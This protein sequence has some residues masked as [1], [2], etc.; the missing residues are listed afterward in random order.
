MRD[1]PLKSA[2]FLLCAAFLFFPVAMALGN[3][4]MILAF[5]LG[6]FALWAG[7]KTVVR[8]LF[9]NPVVVC[10]LGLYL[11][12]VLGSL[13]TNAPS[14]D[15]W[16]HWKKY[17]KLLFVP[18][19]IFLLRDPI[20]Q[21][22]CMT[23]FMLSMGFILVSVYLNIF[24]QLPWSKTQNLGWGQ[25]HTVIGDYITQNIM[26]AFF[27]V[28]SLERFLTE[29][30]M[31][32]RVIWGGVT[33]MGIISILQLSSGRTG[34]VAL[35]AA[36]LIYAAFWIKKWWHLIY[37]GL[38]ALLLM[39]ILMSS[40]IFQNRWNL[41]WI[42]AY[43]WQKNTEIT[44]IGAR[45]QFWVRS[46]EMIAEKPFLGWGTGSYHSQWC[47]RIQNQGLCEV[48]FHPHQQFLFFWFNNGIIGLL[49]FMGILLFPL[50][51]TWKYQVSASLWRLSV[52]FVTIFALNSL[53]NSSLWSAR[54]SHFFIMILCLL[55]AM[56]LHEKRKNAYAG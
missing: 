17:S 6:I 47:E 4:S 50:W 43:N 28:L 56:I 27:V 46:W 5:L 3:V 15:M 2:Q 38:A 40:D 25:D 41:F 26:M 51:M 16:L 19:F 39:G 11:L 44:S 54:Q 8:D 37:M 48:G 35:L 32:W 23:A 34:Y 7:R 20:W 22:R 36:L 29:T 42:E 49:F 53:F 14:A 9:L 1:L 13:Y 45:I 24:F 18:V 21:Q 31:N 52:S 12:L 33:L 30:K 55:C 10:S